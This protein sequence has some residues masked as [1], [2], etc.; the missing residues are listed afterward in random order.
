[1]EAV[2][3]AR[4]EE[5]A[6]NEAI[7][8][9]KAV[10]Q[11][12]YTAN[13]NLAPQAYEAGN[14]LRASELL[15]SLKPSGGSI[16]SGLGQGELRGFEWFYLS[17]LYDRTLGVFDTQPEVSATS[18]SPDGALLAI[19]NTANIEL[20]DVAS[21]RKLATIDDRADALD[22]S[23]DG[24]ILATASTTGS[25]KLW[26]AATLRI[27]DTLKGTADE[28]ADQVSIA[29][30]PTGRII[31]TSA[32]EGTHGLTYKVWNATTH[33][34]ITRFEFGI[35]EGNSGIALALSP[36]DRSIAIYT[37]SGIEVREIASQRRL[38]KF[39]TEVYE[40][41]R[42][43]SF[44]PDGQTLMVAG[45]HVVRRLPL[46]DGEPASSFQVP[47][48]SSPAMNELLIARIVFSP[49]G[50]TF[51]T[52]VTETTV[53]GGE[54]KLWESDSFK[55][56]ATFMGVGRNGKVTSLG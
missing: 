38:N 26:D 46:R 19:S 25:Y 30:S 37:G 56:L 23:P 49:D 28:K 10:E 51:A 43:I 3:A 11:L 9:K 33:E 36:D 48:G 40:E 22:Y 47:K 53:S 4:A 1:D 34:L 2:A 14:V 45:D 55:L 21:H 42:T 20:W 44:S 35:V 52:G 5:V 41:I 27:I 24:K 16:S 13:I 17:G 6:K 32:F 39:P 12:L 8:Q 29:F 31:A 54:V 15:S 18:I 7:A 50:R